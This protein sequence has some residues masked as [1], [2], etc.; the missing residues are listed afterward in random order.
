MQ[1]RCAWCLETEQYRDYHD[2]EWG[3]PQHDD[4]VLFE[5][6]IL[7]SAQAGLSWRTILEKREGYR[8]AFHAFNPHKVAMM[9]T[10]ELETLLQSTEI[11][12]NRLKVFSAVTNAKAFLKTQ[13]EF[14]TFSQYL[15][16]W[17][18]GK[19]IQNQWQSLS[20]VPAH[21]PLSDQLSKDLKQRGFKFVGSTICYAYM[22]AV[23]MV[24]DHVISCGRYQTCKE[25]APK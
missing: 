1:N 10:D 25:L 21:T 15:W 19:P 4:N 7:E 14:G 24:N 5:F 17:V 11:V 13:A 20:D 8:R 23:G 22:Q 12:R 9:T 6:L 2:D 18:A 16:S 3:V